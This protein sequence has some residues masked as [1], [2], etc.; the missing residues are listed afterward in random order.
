MSSHDYAAFFRLSIDGLCIAGIDGWLHAVNPS[1]AQML[2]YS[3]A[4]LLTIPLLELVHPEDRQPTADLL[5][6][7]G[8][9][10]NAFNFESR[11]RCKDGS[12]KWIQWNAP[13][14]SGDGLIYA[15]AR[16]ITA[17]K[18]HS[19]LRDGLLRRFRAIVEAAPFAMLLVSGQ[20]TIVQVNAAADRLF[21]YPSG[22]LL[23]QP[24]D[25]LVP[26]AQRGAHS[27]MREGFNESPQARSMGAGRDLVAVAS[28]G[29]RIAVDIG[30]VPFE[31]GDTRFTLVFVLD[32]SERKRLEAE[33]ELLLLQHS[34]AMGT[35]PVSGQP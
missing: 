35:K 27:R 11:H 21:G 23:N 34:I 17:F 32:I 30:L 28:D 31:S 14:P 5:A 13:A 3:E 2:G 9:G 16:D 1:M 25:L 29:R 20:G 24:V 19:D 10:H 8:A 6:R 18:H 7:L 12:W 33:H 15:V 4:E 26:Q 22:A